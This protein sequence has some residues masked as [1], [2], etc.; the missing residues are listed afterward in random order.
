MPQFPQTV[1][2]REPE[3][4]TGMQGKSEST[5]SGFMFGFDRCKTLEI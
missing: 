2:E 4:E 3:R 1:M 5:A